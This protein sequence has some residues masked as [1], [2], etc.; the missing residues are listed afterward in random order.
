MNRLCYFNGA[1]IPE[2][3]A[4]VAPDDLGMLRGFAVY[5]GIT[6]VNGVPFHF[7]AHWERLINSAQALGLSIPVSEEEAEKGIREV[8][9]QNAPTGRASI[10]AI[11][12]GGPAVGGIEYDPSRSLFYAL[13]EPAG[14]LPEQWYSQGA[15]LITHEHERFMPEYK[16]TGYI[17][18]VLLQ[19]KRKEAGA[20]EILYI[21]DSEVLEC[22]TSNIFI[23]K[24]GILITPIEGV[25]KGITRNV[26][27]EL[28]QELCEIQERAI[29]L[30]ELMEA[31][32]VFMTSSFKDIVPIVS[33]D[34]QA[35]GGGKVGPVTKDVMARYSHALSHSEVEE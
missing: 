30:V 15:S 17:T 16:T 8:L 27:I 4:R 29:S 13:A 9:A 18:A 25:L 6:A 35:V 12:S 24:N 21:S 2:S 32:E 34:G 11:L 1:V 28:M 31:D 10:R 33:I 23:V 14:A 22:A 20:A 19:K 7:N 3:E 5:E 26:V